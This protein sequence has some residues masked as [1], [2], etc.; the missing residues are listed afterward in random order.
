MTDLPI[1]VAL[2]AVVKRKKILLIKRPKGVYS[3]YWALPGGK[4]EFKEHLAASAVREISEEAGIDTEFLRM[5]GLVSE[6]LK[7][8]EDVTDHFI[9]NFCELRPL[10]TKI[11]QGDA[12]EVRWFN[13]DGLDEMREK[14]VPSDY[15]MITRMLQKKEGSYFHSV[16]VK[17]NKE[18][19]L[20]SFELL[21]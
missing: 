17:K 10:S 2:C 18:L 7:E 5:I 12:G 19:I 21:S 20:E 6:H 16:M 13:I 9:L 8:E 1:P 3:G 14:I 11:T 4:I 15:E